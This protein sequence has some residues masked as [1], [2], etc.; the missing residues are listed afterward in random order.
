[1]LT[2]AYSSNN[3]D[4][5]FP[6]KFNLPGQGGTSSSGSPKDLEIFWY[7][8]ISQEMGNEFVTF[9]LGAQF[10]QWQKIFICPSAPVMT[11]VHWYSTAQYA[12]HDPNFVTD[13]DIGYIPCKVTVIKNS[14]GKVS[15]LDYGTKKFAYQYYWRKNATPNSEAYIPGAG[16]AAVRKGILLAPGDMGILNSDFMDRHSGSV[17]LG[18]FDGHVASKTN[19]EVA[20]QAHPNST[21]YKDFGPMF[22]RIQYE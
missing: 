20:E 17:N 22:R 7:E 13:A 12:Y 16:L 4:Y 11:G 18:F 2:A 5:V 3:N 1:M 15:Y 6:A 9:K 21:N 10:N 14:S 8:L 19:G